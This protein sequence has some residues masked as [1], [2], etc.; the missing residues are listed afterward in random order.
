M[1]FSVSL[2]YMG[3][4]MSQGNFQISNVLMN[5]GSNLEYV[6][7]LIPFLIYSLEGGPD[8][9][10]RRDDS[11]TIEALWIAVRGRSCYFLNCTNIRGGLQQMTLS[12]TFSPVCYHKTL[13]ISLLSYFSTLFWFCALLYINRIANSWRIQSWLSFFI[14]YSHYAWQ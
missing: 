11:Y 13:H 5:H 7:S 14:I 2:L 6:S 10:S 1:G 3:S 8:F 4:A 9:H 12:T